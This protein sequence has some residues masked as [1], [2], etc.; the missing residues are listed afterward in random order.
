MS[1]SDYFNNKQ[2]WFVY[3]LQPRTQE[4][5][6]H[7]KLTSKIYSYI[8]TFNINQHTNPA[9]PDLI[10]FFT[11]QNPLSCEEIHGHI[12]KLENI[13]KTSGEDGIIAELVRAGSPISLIAHF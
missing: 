3:E 11:V 13:E 9:S 6:P 2:L 7:G 1:P 8:S 5:K 10:T 4:K 12:C